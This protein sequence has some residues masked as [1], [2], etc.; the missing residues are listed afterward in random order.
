MYR[1]ILTVAGLGFFFWASAG[2]A[3]QQDS[4]DQSM[5]LDVIVVTAK[6]Q[7][8]PLQTGDVDKDITPVMT[9][10]IE[11]E[12]FEG[13]T[14][15]LAEVIKKEA[16]VQVRQS[17]GLGSFSAVSLRGASNQQVLVFLD[18]IL[19]NDA[20]GGGVDLSTIALADVA[21]IDI[22]RGATPMNFGTSGIGGAV[23][24]RT[25]RSEKGLNAS[26]S[27]GYGSFNS[28]KANGF[29]NHKSGRFDYL[30]SADYLASD[31]DFEFL[32]DNGT[33]WN[34][35]DDETQKRENS[36]VEQ[37]NLLAKAGYDTSETL[38]LE[39]M[40]QY[41]S[42]DQEIPSWNNSPTTQT[43]FDTVRNISTAK[44]TADN[45]TSLHLNTSSQ[46]SYTW[47]KE[48]YDDHQGK[49]GLGT[50]H[51]TY[52]TSR[53][54]ADMFVEYNGDWQCLIGTINGLHEDYKD[55]DLLEDHD[56]TQSNRD[57]I[58][59]GLQDSIFLLAETLIVTPA[60]SF[61]W[62]ED[63]LDE[64]SSNF[65]DSYEA[66]TR[67][68]QNLSPQIG[69]VYGPLPWLKMKSNLAKYVRQ[70][71]FFELFGDRGLFVGNPELKEESGV[72]FDVGAKG[73]WWFSADWIQRLT[74]SAA[75]FRND[76]DDLITRA[77]DS[78]GI[79]KSVN[80]SGALIQGVEG[81]AVVEFFDFFRGVMNVTYQD[82]ENQSEVGAF[83][84]KR[85]P[86]QFEYS[87]LGRLETRFAGFTLYG[88]YIRETGLYYDRANLLPAADKDEV[89]A[90]IGWSSGPWLLQ[91]EARNL[92]DE[93][94]ED[95]NGFPLP[96]RSFYM[97]VKY[98]F[99]LKPEKNKE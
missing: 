54:N 46:L 34:T 86:G 75:Y 38:R 4:G 53:V 88:E 24:I 91:F 7:D 76:I 9:S 35:A 32:N 14:E 93:Q 77:Y 71:S 13:K 30:V 17:G 28:R 64:Y 49:L 89:N 52:T 82:T 66:T 3:E 11:R 47:K 90:G 15:N 98:T 80:I 74:L 55:V 83:D 48:E 69:L 18:G 26:V 21:A 63:E 62:M 85:L 42:K 60:A 68:D 61:A 27:G 29:I 67:S 6:K 92:A 43:T 65:G 1:F 79:G 41:F 2:F 84:G 51:S 57:S 72:N 44:I 23:N 25:L 78:R 39:L 87:L 56:T 36:Q 50:Q 99:S 45:L 31:N 97:S 16:G 96:G 73:N 8:Q 22:Y 59:L 12:A 33:L 10:T 40:N 58:T 70:P 37:V 94:Y 5:M 19:L 95:F 20:S 81:G